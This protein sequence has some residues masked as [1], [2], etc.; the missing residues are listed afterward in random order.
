MRDAL[1]RDHYEHGAAAGGGYRNGMRK[2]RLKSGEGFIEYAAPQVAG[3][4]ERFCSELRDHMKGHTEA[5]EDLAIEM[6][7]RGLSVGDI[8]DAF[9]DE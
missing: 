3:G 6:L 5:L 9:K 7:T 4:D 1:G 8:E 2:G